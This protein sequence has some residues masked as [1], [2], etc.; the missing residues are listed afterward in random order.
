MFSLSRTT[1][2][3]VRAK[4]ESEIQYQRSRDL[5]RD[6]WI[7]EFIKNGNEVLG[8]FGQSGLQR[9]ITPNCHKYA[10]FWGFFSTFCGQKKFK[11]FLK[12]F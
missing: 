10:T 8:C 5:S 12:I 2:F 3:S 11:I 1:D 9:K 4:P 7:E 6:Y